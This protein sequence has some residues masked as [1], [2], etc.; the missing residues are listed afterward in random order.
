MTPED[1]KHLF[2]NLIPHG[3]RKGIARR[4]HKSEGEM[5]HRFNPYHERQLPTAESQADLEAVFEECPEAFRG[6][7]AQIE[8][9]WDSWESR[10]KCA[11]PSPADVAKEQHDYVQAEL[12]GATL[13]RKRMELAQSIAKEKRMLAHLDS[14]PAGIRK[15]G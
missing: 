9:Q 3:C 5:S 15:V 7:R 1:W 14:L 6:I 8:A 10:R 12:E 13:H 11:A 4:R 2:N